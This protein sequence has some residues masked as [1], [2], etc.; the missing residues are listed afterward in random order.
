MKVTNKITA[1]ID[2]KVNKSAGIY[3]YTIFFIKIR[4]GETDTNDKFKLCFYTTYETMDLSGGDNILRS[5]QLTNN[6]NHA[7]TKE[8]HAQI[9]HMK[10]M[11]FLISDDQKR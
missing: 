11:C 7:S 5:K 10:S 1:D 8:K 9:D 6:G 3:H 2:V 4:Q